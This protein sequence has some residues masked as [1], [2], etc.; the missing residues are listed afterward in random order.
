M[1]TG[2][3]HQRRLFGLLGLACLAT[4]TT[5]AAPAVAAPKGADMKVNATVEPPGLIAVRI[6][7]DLCP[8]CKAFDPQFPKLIRQTSDLAVLFVTLDLTSEATQKQA[9][10]LVAAMGLESFWTG[11]LSKMGTITFVDPKTN[12]VLAS[13][14]QTDAKKVEA[15]LRKA[16]VLSGN[17]RKADRE[18]S[19]QMSRVT[20]PANS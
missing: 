11:D 10:M 16:L 12:K 20:T 2:M 15:A 9:A 13:V 17:G 14:H 18:H 3:N 7:H 4:V 5:S 8:F 19:E 1:K 6:R